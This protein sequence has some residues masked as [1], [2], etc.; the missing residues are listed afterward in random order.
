[1]LNHNQSINANFI[2]YNL[3]D[4]FVGVLLADSSQEKIW[5]LNNIAK[6]F[7]LF[8]AII[9]DRLFFLIKWRN[10]KK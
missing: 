7:G 6:K 3:S 9:T 10:I 8:D 5:H 1:M 2:Q 4:K